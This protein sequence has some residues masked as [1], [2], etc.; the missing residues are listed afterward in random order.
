MSSKLLRFAIC[1][2]VVL[3]F[4]QVTAYAQCGGQFQLKQVSC[5]CGGSIMA[6]VCSGPGTRCEQMSHTQLC[7]RCYQFF[8]S[9]GCPGS[10]RRGFDPAI[11]DERIDP[12]QLVVASNTKDELA[13]SRCAASQTNLE[14]WILSRPRQQLGSR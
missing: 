13:A 4:A 14:A 9:A 8:D 7:G 10:A 6:W 5:I 12:L 11:L 3:V 1:A 2:T